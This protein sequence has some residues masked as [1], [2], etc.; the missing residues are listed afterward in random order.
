M[1][2]ERWQQVD[3]LFHE[4]LER[5]ENERAAFLDAACGED[6][7]LRREIE[8][9]LAA[10]ATAETADELIPAQVA[11]D[12]LGEQ[13]A[14]QW[15]G[16]AFSHYRILSQ[17]G[18]G[19]MGE[20][21]LAL[22][23]RLDR[24]IA[25]KMLPEQFS[26]DPERLRRFEREARAA[27]ALNH[28][29][30][31]TI[32]EIGES[33]ERRYIATEL[34]EGE[35]LRERM[36][37]GT[38]SFSDA[39]NIATQVA[40]ALDAAHQAGII[41][42]DIK[43]ENVM[44]R[45]DGIV[46]VLDFGL[47]KH[48]ELSEA[49]ANPQS[50]KRN[51][52]FTQ[53]GAVMGTVRYMSP[54]QARGEKLDTRT[55]LFSLGVMLYEMV[56][57]RAPFT[58]GTTSDALAAILRDE[59]PLIADAPK[60]LWAILEKALRKNREDRYLNAGE[61]FA[62]LL[63]L[64]RTQG[65]VDLPK[66]ELS[67]EYSLANAIVVTNIKMARHRWRA[68]LISVCTVVIVLSAAS[69]LILRQERIGWATNALPRIEMLSN[70]EQFFEAYDL[71]TQVQTVL[72]ND[73]TLSRLMPTISDDLSIVTTPP[74]AE[75]R[76]KRFLPDTPLEKQEW[77][78]IG[79]TPIK[80]LQIARGG[81]LLSI[82]KPGYTTFER[83]IT[84]VVTS[85]SGMKALSK[86]IDLEIKLNDDSRTQA[87]MVFVGSGEYRLASWGRPTDRNVQ[88]GD[89]FIDKYEVSNR[90]YKEFISAGGYRKREYWRHPIKKN[91]R[92]IPWETAI[93]E[94]KD[95]T[96]LPGP[97]TWSNQEFPEGKADYPVADISWYEAAAYAAFRGKELP[98]IFQWERAAREGIGRIGGANTWMMP[99]GYFT[100]Q[101]E[102]R[103]N[104]GNR[105]TVPVNSLPFGMSPSGAYHMAG[106]VAEWCRNE[107][108]DGFIVS[109][110][111]WQDPA[112]QFGYYGGYP[113]VFTSEKIGF[114]CVLNPA[115]L[116]TEEGAFPLI[117]KNEIPK[118]LPVNDA[119]FVSW[120]DWYRYEQPPLEPQITETL[121][122]ADWRRET[123]TYVGVK[124]MRSLA[125]LYTPKNT[126]PPWQV[127]QFLP[128]DDVV[129][130][131]NKLSVRVEGSLSAF[132]K[133]GR[134]V[135]SVLRTGYPEKPFPSDYVYPQS[136]TAEY[137]DMVLKWTAEERR[138]LDY[139]ATRNDIDMD[140][141]GF[142]SFS[143][144]NGRKLLQPAVESRYRS[145][146]MVGAGLDPLYTRV[147]PEINPVNLLPQIRAP[148]LLLN[149][150]WD[151]NKFLK[152][153]AEPLFELMRG[154]KRMMV[155]DGGHM[156]PPEYYIPPINAWFDETLGP[157]GAK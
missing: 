79:A 45:H 62:D 38:L 124:G 18:S 156:P 132:M 36:K 1:K 111:A 13:R 28:P 21:Y 130:G 95:R 135:I 24:K 4:A 68:L 80:H 27:S 92:E 51:P 60:E 56:S 121:E 40:T 49:Q 6:A 120:R 71:A 64:K 78:S 31:I 96:G 75:V 108:A 87:G 22:D 41:H 66:S 110:G 37:R 149:G 86:P 97:R 131:F 107:T 93:A 114:R 94:F 67:K 69:W 43:P 127:I 30:I 82:E 90:D 73:P 61:I 138:A 44:L 42:R 5:P 144:G 100:G 113:G 65:L 48:V 77:Q 98:T 119:V 118:Y 139:L 14:R 142:L 25:L 72:P 89:Y 128:A 35:T 57:G 17:I 125:Y 85:V 141:I 155:F 50:A 91:E 109:G 29:N 55:D 88:L 53:P 140:R 154:Q 26:R 33:D 70:S 20:V 112:Y 136:D 19:G 146:V 123:I 8:S 151:E 63:R 11:A 59:P 9:L 47:A 2:P 126:P 117:V 58:G 39:L 12:M 152:F 143:T 10:D 46:K 103:A 101:L 145:I 148:K 74:G 102:H 157:V 7:D 147:L 105:G 32:Y 3:R 104:F 122:T 153:H 134:A 83:T 129:I 54:E 115:G 81:Y 84:G 116:A 52:Q 76:M 133:S 34:I 23:S 99:W 106:N 16:R 15:I 137:R 150:R